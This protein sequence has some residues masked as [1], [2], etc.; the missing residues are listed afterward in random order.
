MEMM[1]MTGERGAALSRGRSKRYKTRLSPVS[2]HLK[3]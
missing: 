3:F 1:M 2:S